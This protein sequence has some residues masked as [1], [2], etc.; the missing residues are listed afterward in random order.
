MVERVKRVIWA[1]A[2][3]P[4][5]EVCRIIAQNVLEALREPTG[6][7]KDAGAATYG[8][9]DAHIG[10]LPQGVIIGQPSKAWRAMIDAARGR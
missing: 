8:I 9:H 10:P 1:G 7:M 5:P 4:D 3:H 2:D 6:E